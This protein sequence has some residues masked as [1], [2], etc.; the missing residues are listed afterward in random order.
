MIQKILLLCLAGSAGTLSRYFVG[1]WAHRF[2]GAHFPYGTLAVNLLGC[3]LIGFI[4][5]LADE[6]FWLGPQMRTI[7]LIGFLGAFTTFSSFTFETWNLFKQGQLALAGLN[8]G[9][10]FIGCF[11]GLLIGVFAA[12]GL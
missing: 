5:T 12:R 8:V 6:R 11:L 2:L 9:L 1:E 7:L 4:G 10:S 3:L